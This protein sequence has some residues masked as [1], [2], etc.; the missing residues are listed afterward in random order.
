MTSY[1]IFG[2]SV[3]K[4]QEIVYNSWS[5]TMENNKRSEDVLNLLA[6]AETGKGHF[7]ERVLDQDNGMID[8][9]KAV[10]LIQKNP[11][12]VCNED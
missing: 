1:L 12:F 9:E 5:L 10:E 8:I 3:L 11:C 7:L 4:A 6:Q 2:K